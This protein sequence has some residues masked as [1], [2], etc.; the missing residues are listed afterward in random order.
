MGP[1]AGIRI[2]ELAGI[3]PGPMCAMLLAD[4][5]AEVILVER[6]G[7]SGLGL[8]QKRQFAVTS[9]GRKSIAL[10][11][12]KPEAIETQ[13][14][15]LEQIARQKGFALGVASAIPGSIDKLSRFAKGL[16]NR[17]IALVPASVALGREREPQAEARRP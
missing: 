7:D 11:L 4:L 1:L 13:L 6:T 14:S 16:E 15:K 2:V 9:R 8:P 17:G 3:G 12:K 10:D 5:G